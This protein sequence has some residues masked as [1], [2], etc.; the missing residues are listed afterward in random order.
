[1][2]GVASGRYAA[3]PS[4][5]TRRP[6]RSAIIAGTYNVNGLNRDRDTKLNRIQ[7]LMTGRGVSLL[8]LQETHE[9]RATAFTAGSVAL[10]SAGN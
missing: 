5:R 8:A 7:S 4:R 2:P 10:H 9:I 6:H 1:M 3:H